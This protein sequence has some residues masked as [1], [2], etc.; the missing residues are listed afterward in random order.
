G[1]VGGWGEVVEQ[2]GGGVERHDRHLLFGFELGDQ[3]RRQRLHHAAHK[4]GIE[5]QHDI[6]QARN[7]LRRLHRPRRLVVQH[8]EVRRFQVFDRTSALLFDHRDDEF[9]CAHGGIGQQK[10]KQ[11]GS[12]DE[13]RH[14]RDNSTAPDLRPRYATLRAT[15]NWQPRAVAAASL[16]FTYLFFLEYLP[17]IRRVHIPFDLEEY[18]YPLADYAFQVLKQGRLPQ[19]D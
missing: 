12:S 11:S 8:G 18:H 9:G 16:A 5:Q 19:W 10:R 2:M 17:P 15:M 1:R 7:Q 3:V 4:A 6:D 14:G 13:G